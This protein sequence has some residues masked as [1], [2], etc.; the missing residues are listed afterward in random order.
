MLANMQRKL[1]TTDEYHRMAEAGIL[2]EDDHLE[3]I[4]GEIVRMAA[5][6]SRHAACVGKLT[7]LFVTRLVGRAIVWGQNPVRIGQYSEPEPDIALLKPR[8][9]FYAQAHPEPEDVLLIVEVADA[10]LGEDREV[11]LKLPL[12]AEAGIREVWIVNLKASCVEVC[13]RPSGHQYQN[14]R[15]FHRDSALSPEMFPDA[16]IRVD[17]ILGQNCPMMI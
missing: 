3:L 13:T 2:G 12:Y 10:S 15:I 7:Q 14:V 1:F 8:E 11:K 9:D 6:G 16:E 17:D 4:R 5:I